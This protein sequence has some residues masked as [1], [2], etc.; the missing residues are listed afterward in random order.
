MIVQLFING[1]SIQLSEDTKIGIT[2]QANNVGELQSRQGSY[3][4]TFKIPITQSNSIAFEWSHSMNSSTVLPYRRLTATYIED[5]V[6]AI[7]EGFAIIKKTDDKFYYIHVVSGNI[8]L[9]KAI[10]EK[11]VGDLYENDIE[12][13]WTLDTIFNNRD[14]SNYFVYPLIDWRS[15]IDTFFGSPTIDV[16]DMIPVARMS[17]MFDRLSAE[18]GYTFKGN[19]LDSDDHKNMLLTPDEF[20]INPDFL[21]QVQTGASNVDATWQQGIIVPEGS[22]VTSESVY[23][24]RNTF[25]GGFTSNQY[26][27]PVD[28]V[29]KLSFVANLDIG[30]LTNESYGLLETKRTRS[31]QFVARIVHQG[32]GTIAEITYPSVSTKIPTGLDA[33]NFT[34]QVNSDEIFLPAG[35]IYYT[36]LDFIIN[37]HDNIPSTVI[38]EG[39]TSEFTHSPTN[40]LSFGS[41]IRFKDIFRMKVKDVLR[42]VLNKRGIII[43]TNSYTKEVHFNFFQDLVDNKP[44]AKDWSDKVDT[45]G[46]EMS[47]TFG[48]YGQKNWLRF[49]ED[50]AVSNELG[51]HFFT[52]DN[53]NLPE[54]KTVVQMLHP[55]TEEENRHLGYNIPMIDAIDSAV[56]WQKPSYRIL[57]LN[58]QETSFDVDYTDGFATS[59][60]SD[61]IPF[62]DFVGFETLV[63]E[64]YA[65]LTDILNRTKGIILPIR[66]T[67]IEIQELD[68]TIPIYLN[69]PQK[70]IDGYFYLNVVSNYK[71]GL[72]S[73]HLIRL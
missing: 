25:D 27:S 19:Y 6:E 15:D 54:E 42:D 60:A 28:H 49:K 43:Q 10:G 36:A 7:S 26:V 32:V 46:Q 48:N 11:I 13:N 2:Y 17:G 71:Q 47:F 24:V 41:P 52:V 20:T 12:Y 18:I 22:G 64:K 3:T 37:Q 23:P 4:N 30:W 72:T 69:I 44:I 57:Q 31:F 55:A 39:N 21:D 65:V 38:V 29:G 14:G 16:K 33:F 61:D 5:G 68:H 70:D 34:V 56:K 8:D 40:I 62:A 63:P 73:C 59:S 35:G 1:R 50:E 51:D 53:E 66:L 58:I 45:R 67:A 9:K